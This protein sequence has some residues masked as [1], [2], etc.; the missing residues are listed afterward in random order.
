MSASNA[1]PLPTR[2]P[3]LIRAL[4]L[5]GATGLATPALGQNWFWTA[6]DGVW[7][8]PLNW[9]PL[10]VPPDGVNVFI[11]EAAGVANSQVTLDDS[12]VLQTLV[13][14]DGMTFFNNHRTINVSGHT[15]LTGANAVPGPGGVPIGYASRLLLDGVDGSSFITHDLT[16]SDGARLDLT[17]Y[18]IAHASGVVSIGTSTRISG[19]GV[20][21]TTGVGSNLVNNGLIRATDDTFGLAVQNFNGGRFD[22][23][24]TSGNGTIHAAGYQ[25]PMRFTAEGLTD[26]FGGTI[27]IDRGA[28]LT[29]D[30]DDG[31][32]ADSNSTIE[33]LNSNF[34]DFSA[35][36]KGSAFTFGGEMILDAALRLSSDEVTIQPS[37]RIRIAEGMAL[38]AGYDGTTLFTVEGGRFELEPTTTAAFYSPTVFYGGEFIGTPSDIGLLPLVRLFEASE[39]DGTVDFDVRVENFGA[40]TISGPTVINAA[41]INMSASNFNPLEQVWTVENSLV[42][43]TERFSPVSP[44][45]HFDGTLDIGGGALGRLTLNLSDPVDSWNMDGQMTLSGLG[46]LPVTRLAGSR[47]VVTGDVDVTNGVSQ[48]TAD[49]DFRGAGVDIESGSTLRTR[50]ATTIDADTVFSGSGTLQNGLG[51]VLILHD[52]VALN[53]VGLTNTSILGIGESGPGIAGVD[54]FL[55]TADA[56]WAV[57]IGGAVAATEHD[58]LSVT[59]GTAELGGELVVLLAD[60]GAGVFA[61]SIGDEFVILLSVGG[62][63]GEFASDPV[64]VVG[65]LTYEWDVV[66]NPNSVVLRLE[67]IVPAPGALALFGI[68]GV[69]ACRRRRDARS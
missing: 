56:I 55:S 3:H 68:A 44:E 4:A 6:G 23:D 13:I 34:G 51:G 19:H 11:G 39:W 28:E 15:L 14:S 57:D 45:N 2:R 66:Y 25:T 5:L 10:A 65:A 61:P 31:W 54:R 63:S 33:I 17:G 24:G 22:L 62:V 69:T 37:A 64:T 52:G 27:R 36:I 38:S 43:N 7:S 21:T 26:T 60:L 47:V 16:L 8:N 35:A 12:A 48:S 50:G 41:I 30:L 40:A 67:S 32:T 59:G 18:A 53:D 42:V 20:L 1:L 9:N 46:A 58:L 49:L 29:M